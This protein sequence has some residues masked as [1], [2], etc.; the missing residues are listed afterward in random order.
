MARYTGP[1]GRINRRLQLLVFENGG[2]RRALERRDT[3]P[4]MHIRRKKLSNYGLAML[5]K[6]K[7]KY[8]YGLGE[9]PLRRLFAEASRTAGNTGEQL[10]VLCERR[11][12]NVIRRSGLASTR[13]QARQGVVHGHFLV[14]GHRV[15]KPS[16]L[17]RPG[18]VIVVKRKPAICSLYAAAASNVENRPPSWL[19]PG[20]EELEVRVVTMPT[21]D[22][23][24]LPVNASSVVELLSR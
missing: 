11:L 1:K 14:N 18:D 6:Q 24:S 5:E 10:L 9:R 21:P 2:A 3:P 17:V 12:D 20:V 15:D 22:E 13:P 16:Y 4:G 7:I 19:A 8:F 23:V